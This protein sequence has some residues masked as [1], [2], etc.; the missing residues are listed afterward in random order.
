MSTT[1]NLLLT[2]SAVVIGGII[3]WVFAWWYYVRAGR[4]LKAESAALR[5]TASLALKA[6]EEV[7]IRFNKDENGDFIGIVRDASC[8]IEVALRLQPEAETKQVKSTG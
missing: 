2:G 5:K 1:T 6:F 7:G 3:T 8:S 4:E